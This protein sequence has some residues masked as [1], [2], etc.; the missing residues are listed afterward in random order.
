[1]ARFKAHY[2]VAYFR[3]KPRGKLPPRFGV[4]TACDPL[5]KKTPAATNR[6][7]DAVLRRLLKKLGLP[8][9]RVTGGSEDGS[10]REPGWGVIAPRETVRALAKRFTQD[11]YFWISSEK[12]RLGSAAGGPLRPAGTWSARQA[13]W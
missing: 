4:V 5:G 13:R 12:V 6:R 1:M 3:A 8:H 10:H 2:F 11:A 9:F 7:R